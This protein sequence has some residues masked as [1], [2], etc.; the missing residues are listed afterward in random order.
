MPQY[1]LTIA[2][3]TTKRLSMTTLSEIMTD[4]HKYVSNVLLP[5]NNPHHITVQE[6]NETPYNIH[7]HEGDEPCDYCREMAQDG[8]S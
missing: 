2:L 8:Q 3:N 4:T 1:R 6:P 5:K 7:K